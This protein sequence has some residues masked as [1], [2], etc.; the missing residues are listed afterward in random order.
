MSTAVERRDDCQPAIVE[1]LGRRKQHSGL[2]VGDHRP[3]DLRLEGIGVGQEPVPRHTLHREHDPIDEVAAKRPD[4]I[5]AD[6]GVRERAERPAEGDQVDIRRVGV[7]DE[8]HHR[9]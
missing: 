9:K 7:A 4:G 3:L 6:E 8:V 2:R 5:R 1:L